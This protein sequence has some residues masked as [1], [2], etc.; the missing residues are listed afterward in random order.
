MTTLHSKKLAKQQSTQDKE[1]NKKLNE[2]PSIPEEFR[3]SRLRYEGMYRM[4][5]KNPGCQFC[6]YVR[7]ISQQFGKIEGLCAIINDDDNK[8]HMGKC[9]GQPFQKPNPKNYAEYPCG[10]VKIFYLQ[11]KTMTVDQYI[12]A[13]V[14]NHLEELMP[15]STKIYHIK[16]TSQK[17]VFTDKETQYIRQ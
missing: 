7:N 5:E 10:I 15:T 3:K 14:I 16:K 8:Y 17:N 4:E 6:P 9:V 12:A 13:L 1:K 2:M 11:K